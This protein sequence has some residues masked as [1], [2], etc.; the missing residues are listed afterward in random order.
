MR[1]CSALDSQQKSAD[2]MI[3][4]VVWVASDILAQDGGV[5]AAEEGLISK[6]FSEVHGSWWKMGLG[7]LAYTFLV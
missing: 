4:V 2:G 1:L 3:V 5:C 7:W 6:D